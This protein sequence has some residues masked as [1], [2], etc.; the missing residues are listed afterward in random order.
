MTFSD[1]R[2][3]CPTAFFDNLQTYTREKLLWTHCINFLDVF[4][5]FLATRDYNSRAAKI[6]IFPALILHS[7]DL[8]KRCNFAPICALRWSAL[9]GAAS[10]FSD[11]YDH[12][13]EIERIE[14]IKFNFPPY[15]THRFIFCS[16]LCC[17][18]SPRKKSHSPVDRLQFFESREKK[19]INTLIECTFYLFLQLTKREELFGDFGRFLTILKKGCIID[20]T[21]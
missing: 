14:T 2:F 16:T 19:N 7:P 21:L 1:Y 4:L 5:S 3:F 6:K 12:D 18:D 8:K 13:C 11:F 17:T 15:R 20:V 10:N 9:R